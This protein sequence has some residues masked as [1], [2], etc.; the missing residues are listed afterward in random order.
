[1][2][3]GAGVSAGCVPGSSKNIAGQT[4]DLQASGGPFTASGSVALK[5]NGCHELTDSDSVGLAL[6]LPVGAALTT[7][8]TATFGLSN[9]M[10]P[11]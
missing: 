10:N 1:M 8:R 6:G 5:L 3:L 9:I 11:D 2:D 7:T 4:V